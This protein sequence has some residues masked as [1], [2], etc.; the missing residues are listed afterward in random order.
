[1]GTFA[2]GVAIVLLVL[3]LTG[4]LGAV[5]I[6]SLQVIGWIVVALL[7]L[8]LVANLMAIPSRL[9]KSLRAKHEM[10]EKIKHK[11]K[12]GYDTTELKAKLDLLTK[13]PPD[14]F[15]RRALKKRIKLG[16][17]EPNERDL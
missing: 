15:A 5:L 9:A 2:I 17:E 16:Y 1:M 8:A 4:S 11:G 3:L 7:G 10:N 6:F 12:L 13:Q 14:R